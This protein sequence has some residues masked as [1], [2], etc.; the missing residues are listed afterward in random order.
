MPVTS[1]SILSSMALNSADSSSIASRLSASGTRRVSAAGRD[2]A[3]HGR[4]QLANRLQRRLGRE[5]RRPSTQSKQST[6]SP[7]PAP[8]GNRASRSS[9]ASVLFPTWTSV[10]SA[11][12]MDAVSSDARSQPC[13][14][15]N[16]IASEPRSTTRTNNRSG[17]VCCSACTVAARSSRAAHGRRPLRRHQ[18]CCRSVADRAG[19]SEARGQNVGERDDRPSSL[20]QT[21]WAYQTP[22]RRPY[23]SGR[24]SRSARGGHSRLPERCAAA[25][26]RM[27]DRS[28][29][30]S[31]LTRTSTMLG[32]RVEVVLPHMRQNHRLRHDL[33]GIPHQIFEQ[34]ELAAGASSIAV[35]RRARRAETADRE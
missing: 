20:R 8:R 15:L 25:S 24:E 19:A 5:A 13:G 27:G 35:S 30:A 9:R 22:M 16:T 17:A 21:A 3:L 23:T 14:W 28:S 33:A 7:G 34:G 10:P 2:D 29:R 12:W 31:R 18:A 6:R 11:S 26:S 1:P 4:D 32:L